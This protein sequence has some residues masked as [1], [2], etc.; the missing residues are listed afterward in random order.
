M[1]NMSTLRK[2]YWDLTDTSTDTG[3]QLMSSALL[4]VTIIGDRDSNTEILMINW[5]EYREWHVTSSNIIIVS[6]SDAECWHQ[7]SNLGW[8]SKKLRWLV[9]QWQHFVQTCRLT[10]CKLTGVNIWNICPQCESL[11]N[12]T[13]QCTEFKAWH[14]TDWA[15]N[16]S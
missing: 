15:V 3:H 12:S 1:P 2:T 9:T 5:R 4:P 14:V 16:F 6:C 10:H 7:E 11:K 8:C 13:M